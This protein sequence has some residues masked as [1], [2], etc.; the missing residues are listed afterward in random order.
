MVGH[1]RESVEA[2]LGYTTL[3]GLGRFGAAKYIVQKILW[4]LAFLGSA[5]MC[6]Y[7]V[8]RLTEQFMG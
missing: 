7:Q 8:Y 3:H 4:T 2:F 1:A 6:F 5:C